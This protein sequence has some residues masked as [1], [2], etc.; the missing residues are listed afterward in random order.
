MMN[1]FQD[2]AAAAATERDA[3]RPLGLPMAI[4][5]FGIPS[6]VITWSL[7]VGI[8]LLRS[9]GYPAFGIFLAVFILPLSCLFAVALAGYRWEQ[10]P[11]NW[12]LFRDR[13]RLQTPRGASMWLW[14]LG[15]TVLWIPI[16]LPGIYPVAAV[17]G[18]L[19][20]LAEGARGRRAGTLLAAVIGFVTFAAYAP[21]ILAPLGSVA[22]YTMPVEV[23]NFMGQIQPGSFFGIALHGQWW[24]PVFYLFPVMFL[25]IFGEELLWRGL[26]LPRQELVYGRWAWVV[27]GLLWT[28]FHIFWAPNLALLLMRAP[29]YLALAFVCQRLQNTWPGI[30]AHFVGNSPVL[31]LIIGGV[32]S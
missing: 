11:W 12:P 10:R 26:L 31:L 32:M 9:A 19:A 23:N 5:W 6:A 1:A 21:Q 22:F 30:I 18:G 7:F 2:P 27:H 14:I 3:L 25:N 4:A 24:L 29:G 28:A 15:L 16:P 17:L 20:V 13:M 8:G